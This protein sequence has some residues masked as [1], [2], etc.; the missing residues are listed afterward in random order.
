MFQ[1]EIVSNSV[2]GINHDL[3]EV[4]RL[5]SVEFY[6]VDHN[7]EGCI[8]SSAI[9]MKKEAEDVVAVVNNC[10]AQNVK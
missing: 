1:V 8:Q 7:L 3:N 4:S 10:V 9:S 6:A 5:A 2:S